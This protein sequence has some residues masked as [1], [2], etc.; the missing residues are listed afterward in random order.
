MPCLFILFL[1]ASFGLLIYYL[2]IY[3]NAGAR[4]A[5]DS[6]GM[7]EALC[8]DVVIRTGAHVVTAMCF[9]ELSGSGERRTRLLVTGMLCVV[10]RHGLH[11]NLDYFIFQILCLM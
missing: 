3:F 2:L 8:P 10:L 1:I 4:E 6:G 5:I 11:S 9:F 7:D